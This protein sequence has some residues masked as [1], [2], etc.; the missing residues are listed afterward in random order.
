MKRSHKALLRG[1][2]GLA[3]LAAVLALANPARVWAQ[4]RQADPVWLVAGLPH[5]AHALPQRVPVRPGG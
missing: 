1:L 4:L 5:R 2:I 3:L